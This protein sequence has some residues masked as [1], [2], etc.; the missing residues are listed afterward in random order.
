MELF[1]FCASSCPRTFPVV[2]SRVNARSVQMIYNFFSPDFH[3]K[4]HGF[5]ESADIFL[6]A[7]CSAAGGLGNVAQ[8][9]RV[10]VTLNETFEFQ[11]SFEI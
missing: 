7:T 2:L 1:S 8:D 11:K 3:C 4:I 10:S 6:N 9:Q 5:L